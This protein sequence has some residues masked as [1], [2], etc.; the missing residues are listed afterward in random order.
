MYVPTYVPKYTFS[1]LVL[2]LVIER[3]WRLVDYE[4]EHEKYVIVFAKSGT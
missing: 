2:V 3:S 1:F 4:H